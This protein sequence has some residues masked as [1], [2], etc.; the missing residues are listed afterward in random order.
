MRIATLLITAFSFFKT[1]PCSANTSLPI[2]NLPGEL[3]PS[4][5]V[6]E[7]HHSIDHGD[8]K[9]TLF[10]QL[11]LT[12]NQQK[13]IEK[14]HRFYYP[15][16]IKL[17]KQL[18]AIKEELTNMMSSTE[19]ATVIRIKHQEVLEIRQELGKLQLETMLE[20]REVLTLEQRQNF[21]EL[22]RARQP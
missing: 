9:I 1:I 10:Q 18:A 15:K 22:L 19:S 5:L 12:A 8:S 3:V 14:I 6:A 13:K 7:N 16:I 11:N 2:Q 4:W 17:K 20:T 21:A